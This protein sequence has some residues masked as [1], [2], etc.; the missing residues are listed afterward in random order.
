V[1]CS[2][3]YRAWLLHGTFVLRYVVV[4]ILSLDYPFDFAT[5]N[6]AVQVAA[7]SKVVLAP[8]D[9]YFPAFTRSKIM[10]VGTLDHFVTIGAFSRVANDDFLHER[11][12]FNAIMFPDIGRI[13]I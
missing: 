11:T 13:L 7:A 1:H 2:P 12:L 8:V 4:L 6:D 5:L 9:E 10:G 3:I